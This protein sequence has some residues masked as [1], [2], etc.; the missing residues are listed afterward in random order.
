MKHTNSKTRSTIAIALAIF[1]VVQMLCV[2]LPGVK[3]AGNPIISVVPTGAPG[4]T[5]TTMIPGSAVG[6]TFVV[7]IRVDNIGSVSPGVNGLSYGLTYNGAVLN[8]T[9]FATKQVSFWGGAVGDVTSIPSGGKTS[10]TFSESAIIVP[11][12]APDE[13]TNTAGVATKLTFKVL[14]A[15]SSN[16][17]LQP[18]DVGIAYLTFPD[19][20]GTSHD[21]VAT[22]E[23]AIYNLLTT[24]IST[25]QHGTSNSVIQFAP[26]S[27]PI[28]NT[29]T[30]DINM[31]NAA[32][33]PIWGWN[34][35]VSWNPAVLQLETVTEGTYLN[36]TPGLF[37]GSQT[38]FVVGHIDNNAGTI[39]QGISDIYLTNTTTTAMFG[40]MANL[41]FEVINYANS[42][43]TLNTGIPTLIDNFGHS[44]AVTLNSAQYVTL[45]PPAP[46]GP[47]ATITNLGSSTYQMGST[48]SLSGLAS[49]PG[50]DVIPNPMAPN[51]PIQTYSW[52][53][54]S[55]PTVA[56]LPISGNS[57]TAGIVNLIA[58]AVSGSIVLQL[59]VTTATN[60]SD[61]ANYV[62]TGTAQITIAPGIIPPTNA[63]PQIDVFIINNS[64]ST[65]FP[66]KS[67]TSLGSYNTLDQVDQYA[68]QQIMNLGATVLFNGQSVANKL[69]TFVVANYSNPSQIIA[70]FV[71]YTNANG[72]AY[73]VYRLPN[74][75]S[76][77]MQFGTYKVTATVDVAQNI[78]SDSFWF[79]Y[80]YTLNFGSL[81]AS[82]IVARGR[83]AVSVN[84]TFYNYDNL[85]ENY[86]MTFTVTDVNNVPVAFL[87]VNGAA[88]SAAY[89]SQPVSL[90]IPLYAF[91]G[92]ATV[93]VDLFNADPMVPSQNALPYCPEATTTFTI[94]A[95]PGWV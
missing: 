57:A 61:S 60:P 73:A 22:P 31:S 48:I 91:V 89:T 37:D 4:A 51:F 88:T 86:W 69:V 33:E 92:T 25:Y 82:G 38:L 2:A 19:S 15:G 81:T 30:I 46:H 7:D 36:P 10:G 93:H 45:P 74:Y 29:F 8:L 80:G 49:T 85:P 70:T 32:Q 35:G 56:G 5:G 55:G 23:N 94:G 65:A 40:T 68:P 84:A 28:G 18:S 77:V 42:S 21:I 87:E 44:Q 16:L 11:S 47:A 90:S 59:T 50:F 24:Q 58:P 75:N 6:S 79:N 9:S 14:A 53:Q 17:N 13:S 63:G 43:I 95:Q 72:T 83:D 39:Q 76:A 41:T 64:T 27:N 71:A 20:G 54:V 3:A 12:G 62:N 1:M 52:T 66:Y 67:P 26:G 78:V 34:L